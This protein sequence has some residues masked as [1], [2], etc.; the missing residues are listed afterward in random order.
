MLRVKSC[1]A[2]C[3]VYRGGQCKADTEGADSM[4]QMPQDIS[5]CH[6]RRLIKLDGL[7]GTGS[8]GLA[9]RGI[10]VLRLVTLIRGWGPFRP[11]EFGP[12][13]G[14]TRTKHSTARMEI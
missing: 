4:L 6:S 5:C 3:E 7:G 8:S 12:F 1:K 11:V 9:E 13:L 2:A 14:T 10:K